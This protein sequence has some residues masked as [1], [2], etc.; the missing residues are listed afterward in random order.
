M[1][2]LIFAKVDYEEKT[3]IPTEQL[4]KLSALMKHVLFGMGGCGQR[5]CFTLP[6]YPIL[7]EPKTHAATTMITSST[8]AGEPIP[9]KLIGNFGTDCEKEWSVTVAMK[10]NVGM[11]ERENSGHIF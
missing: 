10:L 7:V 8:A 6:I 1:L 2:E 3:V 9:P 11:D 5:S 4:E